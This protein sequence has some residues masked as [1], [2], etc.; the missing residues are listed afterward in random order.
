MK[1]KIVQPILN[2][3]K[4]LYNDLTTVYW[5]LRRQRNQNRYS[6]PPYEQVIINRGKK[7]QVSKYNYWQTLIPG[8]WTIVHK[9]TRQ[10]LGL[11]KKSL[12][13]T[14]GS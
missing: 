13:L 3:L 2:V 4:V 7:K 9:K 5:T 1:T 8:K 12:A 14:G 10:R 6:W 11:L